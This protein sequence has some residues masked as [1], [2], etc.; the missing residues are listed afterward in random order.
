MKKIRSAS[1]AVAVF[2]IGLVLYFLGVFDFLENKTY[3]NRTLL[4]SNAV[5]TS[6]KIC[7]VEVD[8]ESIDWA[9]EKMGWGWPWPRSA[10]GD[11]VRYMNKGN[12]ESVL[13]DILFTESS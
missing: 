5:H 3:D 4:T 11:I 1:V 9:K 2:C 10:Y 12:A 13:F 6:D 7:F 8:Q